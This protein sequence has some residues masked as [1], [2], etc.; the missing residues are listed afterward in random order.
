MHSPDLANNA[1]VAIRT[2]LTAAGL[3]ITPATETY[4]SAL[5][6]AVLEGYLCSDGC[7]DFPS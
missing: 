5:L 2:S 3:S 7:M 1:S 6:H 4:L